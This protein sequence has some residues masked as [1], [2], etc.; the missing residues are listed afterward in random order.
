MS[1]TPP[2]DWGERTQVALAPPAEGGWEQWEQCSNTIGQEKAPRWEPYRAEEV[3]RNLYRHDREVEVPGP[4]HMAPH[5]SLHHIGLVVP[6]RFGSKENI[7]QAMA[8]DHLQDRGTGT[9]GATAAT[10]VSRR[11]TKGLG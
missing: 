7:H 5:H 1:L 3:L 8:T 6:K 2:L 11:H 10:P 9:E 4:R